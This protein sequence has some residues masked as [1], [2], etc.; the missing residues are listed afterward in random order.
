MPYIKQVSRERLKNALADADT[1]GMI[2]CM[3]HDVGE[4]NYIFT[5]II[6]GYLAQHGK[7]YQTMNDIVG[8]LESAKAEFQRRVVQNYEDQKIS[9]NGD[10]Y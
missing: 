10:V 5:A 2:G 1:F 8:V 3:I 9:E 7:K 6:H 4:L